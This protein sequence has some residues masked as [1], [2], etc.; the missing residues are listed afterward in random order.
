MTERKESQDFEM[1]KVIN[2]I[3]L[4]M[5]TSIV[6]LIFVGLISIIHDM[7]FWGIL[8]AFLGSAWLLTDLFPTKYYSERR[9][10]LKERKDDSNT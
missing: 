6:T 8:I 7:T 9:V 1:K 3:P 4:V 2:L 10:I 5:D